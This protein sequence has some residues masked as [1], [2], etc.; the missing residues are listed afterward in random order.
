MKRGAAAGQSNSLFG[1][2]TPK[3]NLKLKPSA[4]ATPAEKLAWEKELIGFFISDH[5]M[6]AHAAMIKHYQAQPIA[7]LASITDEKK[8]VRTAGLVSKIHKIFTKSGQ[9][10]MFVTIED[11][12]QMPIELV[13]FNSVLEKTAPVWTENAVVVVEGKISRRDGELKMICEKAK[14][15]ES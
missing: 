15:L 9:P 5:P 13:V 2:A 4:P 11:V 1:E 14:R 7:E 6:N 10:M 8:I 3:F 12:A